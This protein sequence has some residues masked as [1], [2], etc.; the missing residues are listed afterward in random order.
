MTKQVLFW[1]CMHAC[2]V[3]NLYVSGMVSSCCQLNLIDCPSP[4]LAAKLMT[5]GAA[6]HDVHREE[7]GLT[8][9]KDPVLQRHCLPMAARHLLLITI[10]DRLLGQRDVKQESVG[11][12]LIEIWLPVMEVGIMNLE[13]EWGRGEDLLVPPW[14]TG[15]GTRKIVLLAQLGE[16][17]EEMTKPGGLITGAGNTMV[18]VPYPLG[19]PLPQLEEQ[20]V[21]CGRTS[22]IP[23][24][25]ADVPRRRATIFH[26]AVLE[27]QM[28]QPVSANLL[29]LLQQ[30]T[31]AI[32][33]VSH[34]KK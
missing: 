11:R 10:G 7:E 32:F 15:G 2:K 8:A 13:K 4:L 12:R 33:R 1:R 19:L 17:T 28:L 6:F 21:G 3:A 14:K 16:R 27:K 31:G 25:G 24:L 29:T 18:L 30:I 26:L 23:P 34:A 9:E 5:L 20:G 22:A